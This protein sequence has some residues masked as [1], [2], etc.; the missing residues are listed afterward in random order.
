MYSA[1][2]AVSSARIIRLRKMSRLESLIS[3]IQHC[4]A[5]KYAANQIRAL[6]R[7]YKPCEDE[8]TRSCKDS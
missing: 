3:I 4:L 2:V 6:G 5:D 8:W 1:S 7:A